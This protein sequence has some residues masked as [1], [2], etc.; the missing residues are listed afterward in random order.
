[1]QTFL[2]IK[3]GQLFPDF[4]MSKNIKNFKIKFDFERNNYVPYCGSKTR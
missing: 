1:M 4:N 3:Y 2:K